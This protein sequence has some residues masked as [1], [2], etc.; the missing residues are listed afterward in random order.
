MNPLA[1]TKC[2]R[3][4]LMALAAMTGI[5]LIAG[6]GSSGT[7]V[8]VTGAFTNASLKGTYS[9]AVKGFGFNNGTSAA[10]NFFVEGG[11]FTSDGNGTIT[12]GTDDFV[13]A[14]GATTQAFPGSAITGTY[15]IN[16]DGTGDLQFNFAGGGSEVFRITLSDTG[17]L[18]ME[19]ED[20]FG[21][22]A[23]SAHLQTSTVIPSGTFVFRTHDVQVIATMGAMA[24]SWSVI[25]GSFLMD[26]NWE[27]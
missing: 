16:S 8:V 10:A 14:V 21:T 27:T 4:L 5:L 24:I 9:F 13:E 23:C 12:A 15:S 11:V 3:R 25:T 6:C 26:T 7:H 22:S 18:Y 2:A 19:E 17:H 20:G 1:S